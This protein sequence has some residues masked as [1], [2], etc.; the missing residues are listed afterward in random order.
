MH[1]NG[2]PVGIDWNSRIFVRQSKS[3]EAHWGSPWHLGVVSVQ[4]KGKAEW[5]TNVC[6]CH[7]VCVC[8]CVCATASS[9]FVWISDPSVISSLEIYITHGINFTYIV[10]STTSLRVITFYQ[11][12]RVQCVCVCIRCSVQYKTW[13]KLES[14]EQANHDQFHFGLDVL[15]A[16]WRERWE[17]SLLTVSVLTASLSEAAQVGVVCIWTSR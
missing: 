9:R 7:N 16:V 3:L 14:Q 4:N 13:E 17:W 2:H 12:L 8:V 10:Y 1:V 6:V 15:S 11:Y 5:V